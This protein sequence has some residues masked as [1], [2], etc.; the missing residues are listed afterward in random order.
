MKFDWVDYL[1]VCTVLRSLVTIKGT[2][3]APLR[4]AVSRA[5][6]AAFGYSRNYACD[7][8]GFRSWESA[9]D[10][11]RL[12]SH[13]KGKRRAGIAKELDELRQWR[14]ESDYVDDLKTLDLQ[15]LADWA[16]DTAE[17]IIKALPPPSKSP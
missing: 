9:E 1:L 2:T 16:Q 11:K 5:Y 3:E 4:S 15:A 13:L 6:Y 12:T 10:H 14:N 7:Y 17:H 8:L